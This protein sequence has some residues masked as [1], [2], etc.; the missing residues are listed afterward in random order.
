MVVNIR[1]KAEELLAK[2]NRP[3]GFKMLEDKLL[4]STNVGDYIGPTY[5]TSD[6]AQPIK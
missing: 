5:N 3:N 2:I 4:Q 1:N 6:F